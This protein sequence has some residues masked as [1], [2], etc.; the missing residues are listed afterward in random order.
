VK[1]K[2]KREELRFISARKGDMLS[3][4]FQCEFCWFANINK[5]ESNDW[6][7]NDAKQLA[8]MKQVNLDM[9]WSRE[10]STVQN[11]LST[12]LRSKKCS[13]ELGL[14]PIPLNVGPWP[15]TDNCGFQIAIEMLKMSQG[16]GRNSEHYIQFDSI[17]KVRSAY[18]NVFDSSP[19]RCMINSKMK[20]DRGQVF[21]F[22]NNDTDSK[23]FSM[24]IKGCEKRMGRFVKQDC[25]MSHDL[26]YEILV[27]YEKEFDDKLTTAKRKRFMLV[28]GAAFVILW[29][30]ALRGG[31][32]M[33]IESSELIKRRLDGKNEKGKE[34]CVVPLMG[35]FKNEV[36]ERNL[37]IILANCTASGIPIRRWVEG[38]ADMLIAEGRQNEVG[39]AICDEEGYQLEMWKLNG[40][41]H[42]MINNVKDESPKL[43]PEGIIIDDRFNIYRSFRRGATTRAK[44]KGVSEPIIEMNNRWRKFQNKQGSLPNLPMSQLYIDIRQAFDTKIKFSQ[45]L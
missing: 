5:S 8:Y 11:T 28:C 33:M 3:S 41:L 4:P 39:P 6:Y 25:G 22:A 9:F 34:H 14:Q 42:K 10:K 31:E 7:P 24:F 12:L 29:G 43:I 26:L 38:L 44:E 20:S 27:M 45:S 21:T 18:T 36:G 1:W 13:E 19:A 16:R 35:R 23:L 30:G 15:I 37:I 17:R 32:V 2:K 40:E